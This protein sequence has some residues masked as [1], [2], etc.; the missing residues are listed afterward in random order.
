[1]RQSFVTVTPSSGKGNKIVSVGVP[2]NSSSDSRSTELTVTTAGGTIKTIKIEQLG[3]EASYDYYLRITGGF[4]IE[5]YDALQRDLKNIKV[6]VNLTNSEGD[7][8]RFLVYS[9]DTL[10]FEKTAFVEIDLEETLRTQPDTTPFNQIESFIITVEDTENV[11]GEISFLISC[12]ASS[13]KESPEYF[14][15]GYFSKGIIYLEEPLKFGY[16]K[17]EQDNISVLAVEEGVVKISN[18]EEP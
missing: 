15:T 16:S 5:N 13:D 8:K 12:T 10:K 9:I 4:T 1:M 17:G 6:Y 14:S 3:V 7:H 18:S 11:E 2:A